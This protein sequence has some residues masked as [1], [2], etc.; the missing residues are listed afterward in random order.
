VSTLLFRLFLPFGDH[1]PTFAPNNI[2]VKNMAT[3]SIDPKEFVGKRV[4]VTGG[5]KGAG[6]A[7][8]HRL[9]AGGARVA[10]PPPGRPDEPHKAEVFV[11]ADL[12]AADGPALLA[13]AALS[14]FGGVDIVIHCLGGSSTPGGGFAAI[15]DALWEA[16]LNLNLLAAVRLDR[17]LVPGMIAQRSGV[18]IH[19]SSIQRRLPLWESTTA[20]AAAKAA[21]S[22]YSK[23]LS[24]ELGP[25]GVR[26]NS[27]APGWIYTTAAEAMVGRLAATNGV[28][29][30]AARQ[31]ILDALGGIP[32]GRPAQPEEVAELAAF[33]ASDRPMG[34]PPRAS[35]MPWRAASSLTPL[36]AARRPTIA[37]AAVV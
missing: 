23:A 26:V 19:V 10:T 35:S 12:S 31:G 18:V 11:A 2:G 16:E 27:L 34:M 20:Y 8:V 28:S 36:V 5:T 30:D 29:E 22:A 13:E 15:T 9:A 6:Q 24:K 21:L 25:Q 3:W 17:L 32:I 1:I 4:V 14:A 7:I 37:S 33:L